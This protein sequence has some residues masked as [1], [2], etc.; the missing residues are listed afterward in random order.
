MNKK[1][2]KKRGFVSENENAKNIIF[3]LYLETRTNIKILRMDVFLCNREKSQ[4][5]IKSV[6]IV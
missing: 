4:Q 1:D 2:T 3:F 6:F 5:E